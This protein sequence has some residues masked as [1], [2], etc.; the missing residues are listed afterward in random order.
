MQRKE[1]EKGT[2]GRRKRQGGQGE[3]RCPLADACRGTLSRA[4]LSMSVRVHSSRASAWGDAE[5]RAMDSGM[6]PQS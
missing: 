1:T 4:V 5:V 2:R 3:S 6:M